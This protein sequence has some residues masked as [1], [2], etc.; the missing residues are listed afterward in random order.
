[1]TGAQRRSYYRLKQDVREV[2]TGAIQLAGDLEK[3][4][5]QEETLAIYEDLME[6]IRRVRDFAPQLFTTR[7]V[8][9]RASAARQVLNQITPY[10]DPDAAPLRPAGR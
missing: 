6:D 4:A 3:G 9:E 1:M 10:Y 5:T 7:D 8:M 2:R